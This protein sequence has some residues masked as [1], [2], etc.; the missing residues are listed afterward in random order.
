MNSA[1]VIKNENL[2]KK[3]QHHHVISLVVVLES[4]F[5]IQKFFPN[6]IVSHVQYISNSYNIIIRLS[7]LSAIF[8]RNSIIM[9]T[10]KSHL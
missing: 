6:I 1:C 5:I 3:F 2:I 9:K 4:S 8:P 10:L 7:V